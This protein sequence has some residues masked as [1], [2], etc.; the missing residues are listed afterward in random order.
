MAMKVAAQG[1]IEITATGEIG[2]TVMIETAAAEAVEITAIEN[3]ITIG[4][5][6]IPEIPETVETH[7]GMIAT[8]IVKGTTERMIVIEVVGMIVIEVAGMTEEGSGGAIAL[9]TAKETVEGRLVDDVWWQ[10]SNERCDETHLLL[11]SAIAF[12]TM[13]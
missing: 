9:E 12:N 8:G 4:I 1:M 5:P 7:G 6:E 13:T 3:A 2:M 10:I 11:K